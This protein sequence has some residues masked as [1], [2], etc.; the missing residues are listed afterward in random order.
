MK[1]TLLI[2]ISATLVFYA[3]AGRA[4]DATPKPYTEIRVSQF[5]PN[6]QLPMVFPGTNKFFED[7]SIAMSCSARADRAPPAAPLVAALGGIFIDWLFARASDAIS[8]RLKAKIEKYTVS[9]GSSPVYFDMF[10]DKWSDNESCVI[11]QQ[12]HCELPAADIEAGRADCAND[13]SENRSVALSVG[14]KLKQEGQLLRILPY[15]AQLEKLDQEKPSH[16]GGK[17]TVAATFRIDAM[18]QNPDGSG[19]LWKS[20]DVLVASFDCNVPKNRVIDVAG[21]SCAKEL[22]TSQT[23]WDRAQVIPMPPKTQQAIVIT[24]GEVGEQSWGVRTL[25]KFFDATGGDMS[26]ALSEAFQKKI[27]LKDE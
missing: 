15:A 24:V 5:K 16:D 22:A 7:Q 13:N 26:K 9:Y 8:Q 6:P 18:G 21:K 27:K 3:G 19:Y 12:I 1:K 11:I 17:L 4:N 25:A 23:T 14:L 2:L 20:P 10:K